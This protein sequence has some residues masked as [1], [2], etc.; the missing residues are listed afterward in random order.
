[1]QKWSE[2]AGASTGPA[3]VAAILLLSRQSLRR[4]ILDSAIFSVAFLVL[5]MLGFLKNLRTAGSAT[6]RTLAFHPFSLSH[7]K[8]AVAALAAWGSPLGVDQARTD[9]YLHPIIGV[10]GLLLFLGVAVM[11]CAIAIRRRRSQTGLAMLSS[12]AVLYAACFVALIIFSIS[13]V[14]FHTPADSRIL[15]PVYFAWVIVLACVGT[16][17]AQAMPLQRGRTVV[18]VA[19][20]FAIY[21]CAFP[22][23]K[24]IAR[25]F[26]HGEGFTHETWRNS[27]TIAAIRELPSDQKIFTNAPGVIYLLTR[28]QSIVTVPSEINASTRLPNPEYAGLMGRITDDLRGGRGVLVYLRNYGK[29]RAFYPTEEELRRRLALHPRLL[30]SDGGI[31]DGS[32]ATTAPSTTVPSTQR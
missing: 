11:G 2:Y 31:Y 16:A 3:G 12:V 15:S 21:L 14:D 26:R 19:C 5:P 29:R 32:V 4:R 8:D 13:F 10:I 22:S 7:M 27:P 1:M 28:R 20:L 6:N 9:V 23:M 24:L 25:R 18:V 17:I 30:L